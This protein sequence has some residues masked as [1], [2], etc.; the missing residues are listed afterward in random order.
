MDEQDKF[1]K[2]GEVEAIEIIEQIVASAPEPVSGHLVGMSLEYLLKAW[3]N[4]NAIEDLQRSCWYLNRA[5]DKL[6]AK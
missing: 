1:P 5:L 6:T 4:D 3:H 2:F